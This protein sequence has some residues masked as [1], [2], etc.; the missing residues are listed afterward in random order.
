MMERVKT[1][2]SGSARHVYLKSM[3]GYLLLI[4]VWRI[5]TSI[6]NKSAV[7]GERIFDPGFGIMVACVM[8]IGF[9]AITYYHLTRTDEHDRM[10]N[11][12][13]FAMAFLAYF[14][15]GL[16]WSILHQSGILGP[17]IPN[18]T[19]LI[20]VSVGSVVWIWLRL[21]R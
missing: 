10:V 11:L 18:H 1:V 16:P 14:V 7:P 6:G 2:S 17:V 3:L 13:A 4:V 12:W 19:M 8:T 9:V 20:A 15:V 5:L 21:F